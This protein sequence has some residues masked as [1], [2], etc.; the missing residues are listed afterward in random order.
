MDNI[1]YDVCHYTDYYYLL[2]RFYFD[3]RKDLQNTLRY[4]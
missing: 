4:M 1:I 2:I 3:V